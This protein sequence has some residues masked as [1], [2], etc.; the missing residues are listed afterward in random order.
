MRGQLDQPPLVSDL[1]AVFEEFGKIKDVYI[2]LDFYTKESRGF[3]YVDPSPR[4][5]RNRQRNRSPARSRSGTRTPSP[6]R[7]TFDEGGVED[8]EEVASSG[9]EQGADGMDVSPGNN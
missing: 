2:P 7:R 1:K 5:S 4:P 8:G 3:G 6:R 9:F